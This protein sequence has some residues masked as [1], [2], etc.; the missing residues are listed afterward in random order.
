MKN[1]ISKNDERLKEYWTIIAGI[2]IIGIFL[3]EYILPKLPKLSLLIFFGLNTIL[4]I[5]IISYLIRIINI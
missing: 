2:L 3:N 1:R 4:A 5:L